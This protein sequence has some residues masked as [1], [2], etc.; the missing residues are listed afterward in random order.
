MKVR[1]ETPQFV[2]NIP[3]EA[4]PVYVWLLTAAVVAIATTVLI[5]YKILS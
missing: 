5:I 3:H 2:K 1:P 4:P